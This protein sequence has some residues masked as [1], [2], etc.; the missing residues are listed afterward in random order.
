MTWQSAH[1]AASAAMLLSATALA[2]CATTSA[3]PPAIAYDDPPREIAA[4]PAAQPPRAVEVVTI[5]E[6]LPLPGQLKP[7]AAGTATSE[8]ADPRRRVGAANAAARVQPTRDGYVNAIQQYPWTQGALYQVYTAP[9]QVTDIAL[10]EG[11]QL[12]GPGPVAAGDTVRWIIGDTVSGSGQTARVH[13]LV[14]PTRPDIGTNLVINTDRRTYH[15]ELRATASTYMASVSWTY[16]Q[17]QLIALRSANAAA[18]VSAPVAAGIDLAA[19]NFRYRIEG[20]RVPWKPVRAFDD[21]AQVFI[22]FPAG[23]SQG[24]MPPLFVTGAAGDAE[25]VNYRVQGRYMVVDRLFAAAELR[26]GDRRSE[27]RVRIVRDDGRRG[28]P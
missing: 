2:G 12:V 15:I 24:E 8:P 10:Q 1:H 23:I 5:P 7:L 19:L 25:L 11:E 18:A 22:E 4:T 27:Q 17:D 16:P 20:D 26:L 14:K 3:K 9:G 21:S 13:I 28:R 6:P